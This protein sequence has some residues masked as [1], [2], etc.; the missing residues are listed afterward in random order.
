[1]CIRDRCTSQMIRYVVASATGNEGSDSYP[2]LIAAAL[3]SVVLPELVLPIVT[4]A[5]EQVVNM[6]S[7]VL[8]EIKDHVPSDKK[9]RRATMDDSDEEDTD[10]DDGGESGDW[11]DGSED[12]GDSDMA[13]DSQFRQ[14][15]GKAAE[16]RVDALGGE[17]DDDDDDGEGVYREVAELEM[18]ENQL[19]DFES[20]SP[21]DD[22]NAWRVLCQSLKVLMGEFSNSSAAARLLVMGACGDQGNS[23]AVAEQLLGG[24]RGLGEQCEQLARTF[25]QL[26]VDKQRLLALN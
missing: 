5:S 6:H 20:W 12:D 24:I 2:A 11:E 26:Q 18:N 1:M 21:I 10:E 15:L 3:S 8:Q 14:I 23:N 17:D 7:Y 22:F 19:E 13:D 25:D 9:K 16:H 4:K